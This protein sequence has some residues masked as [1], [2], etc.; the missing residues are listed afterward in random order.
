MAVVALIAGE[1]VF[2]N[3]DESITGDSDTQETAHHGVRYWGSE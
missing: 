3:V 2:R 1:P